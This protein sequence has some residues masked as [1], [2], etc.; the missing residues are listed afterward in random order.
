LTLSLDSFNSFKLRLPAAAPLGI[1]GTG[2]GTTYV[3]QTESLALSSLASLSASPLFLVRFERNHC[4][5][6]YKPQKTSKMMIIKLT[7]KAAKR[8]RR[9][10]LSKQQ[11]PSKMQPLKQWAKYFN[12]Y[13]SAFQ[14][15]VSKSGQ[16]IR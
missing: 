12:E 2:R 7:G 4:A 5:R 3:F 14:Q 13:Q 16:Q 8:K 15:T 11:V 6:F 10:S 1:A 9:T